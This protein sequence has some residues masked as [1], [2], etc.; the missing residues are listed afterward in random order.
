MNFKIKFQNAI[1]AKTE[2]RN[3]TL[4]EAR[5]TADDAKQKIAELKAAET[6]TFN[7]DSRDNY[8][9]FKRLDFQCHVE[10]KRLDDAEAAIAETEAT[11]LYGLDEYEELVGEVNEY[12]GKAI[13]DERA[14]LSEL[15]EALV[16]IRDGI[17]S[18][19]HDSSHCGRYLESACREAGHPIP[20]TVELPTGTKG[21]ASVYVGTSIVPRLDAAIAG[22]EKLVE[23]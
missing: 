7:A 9:A 6:R 10:Q 23:K 21:V 2:T 16:A 1:D 4:V 3:H 12:Y 8:E 18:A 15:V 22:L 13:A 17:R 14:K 19:E 20:R 5:K 11:P